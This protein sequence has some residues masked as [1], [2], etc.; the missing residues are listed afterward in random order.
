[1]AVGEGT[2]LLSG[3]AKV[4]VAGFYD[5]LAQLDEQTKQAIQQMDFD[6]AKIKQQYGLKRPFVSSA[7]KAALVAGS[8]LTIN[9]LSSG[10]EGQ[11]AKT[12]I[13]HQARAKLDCRLYAGQEPHHIFELIQQQLRENGFADLQLSYLAGEEA[14]LTPLTNLF[15]Q[16]CLQT[17]QEVYG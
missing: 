16:L 9:G 15:V 3:W 14:F 13:P 2:K 17:A 10:Y 11:G 8:T 1:M 6:A 4:K 12:I 5:Q 7:P